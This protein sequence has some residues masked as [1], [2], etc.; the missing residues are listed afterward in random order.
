MDLHFTSLD[1]EPVTVKNEFPVN[2]YKGPLLKGARLTHMKTAGTEI[3]MQELQHPSY[4]VRLSHG[5]MAA[6][7]RVSRSI[8]ARGLYCTFM[9]KNGK[10]EQ[11][12]NKKQVR[13]SQGCYAISY[14]SR[15]RSTCVLEQQQAFEILELFF[16]AAFLKQ[17]AAMFPELAP[18]LRFLQHEGV[19][20]QEPGIPPSVKEIYRALLNG[21]FNDALDRFYLDV[22]MRELLALLLQ[23]ELHSAPPD[24]AFSAFEIAQIRKARDILEDHMDKKPPSLR[25]LAHKVAL[26]EYKLKLGFKFLFKSGM[27]QWLKQQR[28][29][30]AKE[31]IITTD[32]QLK[33]IALMTGYSRQENFATAFRKQFGYSPGSLRRRDPGSSAEAR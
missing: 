26:N 1:N 10:R 2:G 30:R 23:N 14:I 22:K 29:H 13:I 31:L 3:F 32:K 4:C 24:H 8:K 6:H 28:L 17:T 19:N 7:V 20:N 11:F 33:E 5:S 27:L 9:F 15:C 21:S 18:G 25:A 16:T 12:G